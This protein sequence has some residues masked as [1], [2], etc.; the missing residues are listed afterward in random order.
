MSSLASNKATGAKLVRG[1]KV[2][3]H[4]GVT[5][6]GGLGHISSGRVKQNQVGAKLVRKGKA[7]G[8]GAKNPGMKLPKMSNPLARAFSEPGAGIPEKKGGGGMGGRR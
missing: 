8:A 4:S 5:S 6:T 7:P 3:G 1:G 2:G